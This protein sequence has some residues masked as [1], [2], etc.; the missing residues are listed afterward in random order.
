MIGIVRKFKKALWLVRHMGFGALYAML[1]RWVY[2]PIT[3]KCNGE[4]VGATPYLLRWLLYAVELGYVRGFRCENGEFVIVNARGNEVRVKY[5]TADYYIN[6]FR[7]KGLGSTFIEIFLREDYFDVDV[8][9]R[10]V[11]DVGAYVGD[12]SIYF[13]QRGAF[14]VIAIEPHPFTYDMLHY[15]VTEN[16]LLFPLIGYIKPVNAGLASKPGRVCVDT[17]SDKVA[18]TYFKPGDCSATVPAITLGELINMFNIDPSEAVL[19][20]DCEGCEYDVVL[21]DYGHV[22]LFRE[23]VFEYHGDPMVLLNVLKNDFECELCRLG[24][25]V[26][27]IHCKHR[28]RSPQ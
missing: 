17:P 22:R 21:N 18:V 6:G 7:F 25:G 13:I 19:K 12:S 2:E 28:G 1:T 4:R 11:V 20:M 9:D 8:K 14:R 5:D 23:V 10:D 16:K 3:I 26:G 24:S 15:H 27:L